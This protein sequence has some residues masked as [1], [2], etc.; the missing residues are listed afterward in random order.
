MILCVIVVVVVGWD[1]AVE[2]DFVGV[3]APVVGVVLSVSASDIG[4]NVVS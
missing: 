3:A 1:F 2:V 4:S